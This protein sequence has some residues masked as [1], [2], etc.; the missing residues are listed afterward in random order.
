M[1]LVNQQAAALIQQARITLIRRGSW[2]HATDGSWQM[3]SV[4]G[5]LESNAGGREYFHVTTASKEKLVVSRA[6][7]DRGMRELRL[8]SVLAADPEPLLAALLSA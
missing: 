1:K 3:H 6:V 4:V 2:L 8:E 5:P 7:G